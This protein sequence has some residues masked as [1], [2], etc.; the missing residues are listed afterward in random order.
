[1]LNLDIGLA[2]SS[3]DRCWAA[4]RAAGKT[5]RVPAREDW[6]P[7]F[8]QVQGTDSVVAVAA[9]G[10]PMFCETTLTTVTVSDPDAAPAYEP[11]TRTGLLLHSAT[12][13]VGGI[14]DPAWETANL[15]MRKTDEPNGWSGF[16]LFFSPVTRQFV[17]FTR[18]DPAKA[19]L[20]AGLTGGPD[21]WRPTRIPRL[22]AFKRATRT[23]RSSSRGRCGDHHR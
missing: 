21:A 4:L 7:L 11:G 1:M 10:K 5:D 14:V 8:T 16:D 2:T 9:A 13:L 18:T 6:V 22:S 15:S 17:R 3:M 23:A 19:Q 20:S 12:G